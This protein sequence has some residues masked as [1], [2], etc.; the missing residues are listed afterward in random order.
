MP[1]SKTCLLAL[2]LTVFIVVI[3][4]I[5]R[6]TFGFQPSTPSHSFTQF[7]PAHFCAHDLT[8]DWA[9][10]NDN[11]RYLPIEGLDTHDA[12]HI[13]NACHAHLFMLQPIQ[14]LPFLEML[15]A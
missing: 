12:L 5:F 4:E 1:L 9:R 11:E 3:A 8:L 14:A 15:H 6:D 10:L 2:D 13:L 7:L